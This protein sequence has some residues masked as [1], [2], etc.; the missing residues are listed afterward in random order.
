MQVRTLAVLAALSLLDLPAVAAEAVT[1]CDRLAASPDDQKRVAPGIDIDAL[2]GKAAETAC[3]K[4]LKASPDVARFRYQ[5]GRALEAEERYVAAMAAYQAAFDKGYAVGA[6]AEGNL[7]EFGLGRDVDYDKAAA[8]YQR[9]LDAGDVFAAGNLGSLHEEG[10]GFD[11]DPAAAALLY[12]KAAE[13]GHAASEVH[14]GYLYQNGSGVEQS[15]SQAADWYRKAADQGFSVGQF[16]LALM[17]ADGAGVEKNIAEA[18]RLLR[19]AADQGDGFALLELA[20]YAR[21]GTGMQADKVKAESLFRQAIASGDDDAVWSAENQ[22]ASMWAEDGKN[23]DEAGS[24]AAKA[25]AALP[26]AGEDRSIVLDTSALIAHLKHD[27]AKALPL[28]QE[29]VKGDDKYAPYHDRLGDILVALGRKAEAGAEWQTALRLDPPDAGD[30]W[31]RAAVVRKLGAFAPEPA[32]ESGG[33][34][35]TGPTIS[36]IR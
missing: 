11:K 24:L 30:L 5:L 22:L 3:R 6:E 12:R 34:D 14:L 18:I 13:A 31:D 21:D 28:Q 33:R 7:F 23:L 10:T 16:D 35:P 15:D 32:E 20:R 29:A 1:G 27:D 2:D 36:P 26:D 4:A 17:Y 9:A 8:Y 25:L 19:L